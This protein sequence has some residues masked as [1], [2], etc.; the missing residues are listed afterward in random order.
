MMAMWSLAGLA[1]LAAHVGGRLWPAWNGDDAWRG[2][3]R[4]G[5]VVAGA[6]AIPFIGWYVLLTVL[7]SVGLGM[8]VRM[9]FTGMPQAHPLPHAQT[10][11]STSLASVSPPLPQANA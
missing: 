8:R 4:G 3:W 1:G 11:S 9:W 5:L 7:L 2:L 10:Q 6:L